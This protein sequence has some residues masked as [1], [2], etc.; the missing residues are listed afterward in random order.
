MTT[1]QPQQQDKGT[2]I[3]MRTM[4]PA[5]TPVAA[6]AHKVESGVLMDDNNRIPWPSPAHGDDDD[7]MSLLSSA[8][9]LEGACNCGSPKM[10]DLLYDGRQWVDLYPPD[11]WFITCRLCT[12]KAQVWVWVKVPTSYLCRSQGRLSW[13][14]FLSLDIV[15]QWDGECACLTCETPMSN[16]L[17]ITL[18]GKYLNTNCTTHKQWKNILKVHTYA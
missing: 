1:P 2:A 5:P 17:L 9:V 12:G 18:A 14:L 10:Q 15:S 13:D 3:G 4:A 7:V 6:T 11:P 16:N 8:P